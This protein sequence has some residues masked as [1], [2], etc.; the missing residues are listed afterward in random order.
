MRASVVECG[1]ERRFGFL[2][3]GVKQ[4]KPAPRT[5]DI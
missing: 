3:Q 4:F 2:A 5:K 1:V